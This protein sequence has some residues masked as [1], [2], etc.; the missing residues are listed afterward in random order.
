MCGKVP[1]G[2]DE[3]DPYFIY[4]EII[5]KK[6]KY[7]SY[8]KDIGAKKLMDQLINKLPDIRLGGSFAAL[9]ANNWFKNFNWVYNIN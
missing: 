2:E 7:P 5:T 4:Q 6:I 9:K 8:M 3:D 1:F